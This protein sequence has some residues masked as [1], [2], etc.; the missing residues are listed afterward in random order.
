MATLPSTTIPAALLV[1]ALDQA[2]KAAVRGWERGTGADVVPG[3]LRLVHLHNPDGALGLLGAAP[4]D[5]RL[6]AFGLATGALLAVGLSFSRRAGRGW[7]VGVGLGAVFGGALGNTIDR[8]LHGGV[9]DLLIVG[10]GLPGV[11]DL[12]AVVGLGG[13]PAFN[14]AD[15]ALGAGVTAL[16]VA[17]ASSWAAAR[18]TPG[19]PVVAP[20]GP[21]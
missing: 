3:L 10:A 14:F 20:A 6:L 16:G 9:T 11:V 7:L 1:V 17:V 4:L 13:P 12:L 19:R 2:S 15:V 8:A 18:R 5:L 21:G